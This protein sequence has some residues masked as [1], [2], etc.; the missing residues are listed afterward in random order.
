MMPVLINFKICDN[1][2]DCNGLAACPFHAI[3]WNDEDKT[4]EINNENCHNC[5][6][7]ENACMVNAI[8]VAKTDAEYKTIEKDIEED[9]RKSSDL[10]IDRYGAM[11][12]N[13][14]FITKEE[15]FEKEIIDYARTAVVELFDHDSIACLLRSIPIKELFENQEVRYRKV[16]VE[17]PKLT[18]QY[19]VANLP[20]LLFFRAGEILGKI[21]GYYEKNETNTL[22]DEINSII[23]STQNSH[24]EGI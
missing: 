8:H 23:K 2:E 21:E 9:S 17:T 4:L 19:N 3:T 5:G 6:A 1:A 14:A 16:Q 11:P 22:K 20:A 24:A 10:F 15:N 7:C 12:I 18:K 13:E